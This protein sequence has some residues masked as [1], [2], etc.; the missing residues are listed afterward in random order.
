MPLEKIKHIWPL[1]GGS[2]NYVVTLRRILEKLNAEDLTVDQLVLWLKSEYK[3]SGAKAPYG[4]V[5]VVKDCLSFIR[6]V[7]GRLK[8]VSNA[9]EFLKTSDNRLVFETLRER[10]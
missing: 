6:E 4:Y 5:R 1:P 9:E 8:L 2:R 10:S 3:L 7:D